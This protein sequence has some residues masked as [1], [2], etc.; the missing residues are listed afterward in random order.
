VRCHGAQGTPPISN[1]VPSLHGQSAPYLTRAISEY[2]QELRASGF[3]A[4]VAHAMTEE[5]TQAVVEYYAELAPIVRDSTAHEATLAS[6]VRIATEGLPEAGVPPCLSC[7]SG[8]AS[9]QFPLLAGQSSR[10]IEAQLQVWRAG[11]RKSSG[12]GA[13]MAAIARRLTA[14]QAHDVAA[15]FEAQAPGNLPAAGAEP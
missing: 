1:L 10:Y 4:P 13:I 3:M 15:W 12:Y 2:K 7:H 14:A 8:R 6:G 5:E 11:L 9:P